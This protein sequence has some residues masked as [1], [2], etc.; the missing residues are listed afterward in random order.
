[1]QA[2]GVVG[3][4]FV[5]T[6]VKEGMKHAFRVETYDINPEKRTVLSLEQLLIRTDGPIFVAVPT[7]MKPSGE[8][9]TSI[10][11]SVVDDIASSF[12]ADGRVIVIKSTVPP[13][14]TVALQQAYP[15][16]GFIFNPEFLTE[17]NFIDDFKN[18]DRIILGGPDCGEGIWS[19]EP[20]F[21]A[22]VCYHKAF[23]EVPQHFA[24]STT[25][26]MVKYVANSFLALKVTFANEI[27]DV[28][29]KLGVDFG[30]V[31]YLATMDKRLGESHWQ[32]PGPDGHRGFGGSCFPKDVNALS[33]FARSL[34]APVKMLEAARDENAERFRPERDWEQLKGRAVSSN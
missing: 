2:I 4:G 30:L 33:F 13:G 23:P 34:G 5:G 3:G 6:A 22:S 31:T 1:M 9:D 14:T 28:A 16:I 12:Y 11:F 17:A 21:S 25:A 18:Q 32:V 27:F 19:G 26:E 10:V 20:Y 8:C 15:N 7:P 29:E 24:P